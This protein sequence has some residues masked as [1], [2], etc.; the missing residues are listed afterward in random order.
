MNFGGERADEDQLL[1]ETSNYFENDI[2]TSKFEMWIA[3]VCRKINAYIVSPPIQT[4]KNNFVILIWTHARMMLFT[5]SS[6][7]EW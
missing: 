5:T 6:D 3:V 7:E 2:W 1:V 4:M